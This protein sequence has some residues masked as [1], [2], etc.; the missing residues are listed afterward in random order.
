MAPWAQACVVPAELASDIVLARSTR[1]D[2][3]AER[4]EQCSARGHVFLCVPL[5]DMVPPPNICCHK[6]CSNEHTC[7]C[8]H[9][10]YIYECWRWN[11]MSHQ[12]DVE[13]L[14]YNKHPTVV[15]TSTFT[16]TGCD[17]SLTVLSTVR[18][19]GGFL[20]PYLFA[21]IPS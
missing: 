12:R 7:P 8:Y 9:F 1:A 2:P 15:P 13:F 16:I 17:Q 10:Y 14:N 19:K 4:R 18:T 5:L 11:G 21:C 3:A 6:P 20:V